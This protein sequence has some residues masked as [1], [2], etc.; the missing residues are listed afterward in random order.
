MLLS[1]T[2][3]LGIVVS[4]ATAEVLPLRRRHDVRLSTRSAN[5][6]LTTADFGLIYDVEVT[7]GGQNFLLVAD[8]GSSDLWV[9]GEG[10]E[11]ISGANNSV[12][13]QGACRFASATYH[14]SPTFKKTS[15][16]VFGAQYG[17]GIAVGE[18]G[19]EEVSFAGYTIESQTFGYVER[20]TAP[21][22][23]IDSGI[24]GLGYPI[25]TSGHQG[26]SVDNSSLLFNRTTYNPVLTN[27][28]AQGSI[29]PWYSFAIERLQDKDQEGPGGFLA[30][31]ELPPVAHSRKFAVAPVEITEAIPV[32]LTNNTRQ[33]TEWTLSVSQIV[34]GPQ[35][36]PGKFSNTTA[37][38]AIVDTGSMFNNIP[39]EVFNE[40][41]ALVD[42]AP[43]LDEGSGAYR[44]SCNAKVPKLG[45]TIGDQT[46]YH[47]DEDLILFNYLGDG[48]CVLALQPSVAATGLALNFI[49]DPLLKNVVSVFDFGKNEMRFAARKDGG[50]TSKDF[51]DS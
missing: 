13:P 9:V 22:S 48:G 20:T 1:T 3:A 50:G 8:T 36:K 51:S 42:P 40:I 46:F 23:G 12:I 11:C 10:Y 26:D 25:L 17:V 15:G 6:A 16:Q 37:F 2:V 49:G 30:L 14:K 4:L 41:V 44:V 32:V 18:L 33:I 7:I 27:L 38:Q 5:A 47:L 34:W 21:G 35:D 28:I 19:T 24:L 45:V 39:S 29:D 43:V 31:G